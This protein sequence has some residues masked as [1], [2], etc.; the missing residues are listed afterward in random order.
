MEQQGKEIE[1]LKTY[2]SLM[3]YENSK[4]FEI[5]KSELL[6]RGISIGASLDSWT[7]Q[8]MIKLENRLISYHKQTGNYP[9]RCDIEIPYDAWDNPMHLTFWP[10][11]NVH[12]K[13]HSFGSDGFNNT[14]DDIILAY[15]NKYEFEEN[16]ERR[17]IVLGLNELM[18]KGQNQSDESE[19][20]VTLKELDKL[21]SSQ[22]A[23][24][25]RKMDLS[26]LLE[27]DNRK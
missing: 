14:A 13:I 22:N 7:V 15:C 10:K 8:K 27:H 21:E 2:D 6:E 19:I 17:E 11:D 1:T 16:H 9:L 20:S 5:A 25:E 12:F 23:P 24:S 26:Q 4:E 3:V 18:N